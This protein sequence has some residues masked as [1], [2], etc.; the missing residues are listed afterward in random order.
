M[1]LLELRG[2]VSGYG[3]ILALRG[4]DL[5]VEEGAIV[6]LIGNN[7]AGKTTTLRTISGLIRPRQ[8]SITFAGSRISGLAAHEIVRL[9]AGPR[10][11]RNLRPPERP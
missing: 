2:I 5:S 7:G 4:I 10:R 8:G 6:A 9:G 11:A 3:Q 1:S